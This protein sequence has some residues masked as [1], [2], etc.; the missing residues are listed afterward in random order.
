MIGETALFDRLP[1][2]YAL[3]LQSYSSI[4]CSLRLDLRDA[5]IYETIVQD[6]ALF[7]AV[8]RP[9]LVDRNIDV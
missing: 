4:F 8:E 5:V 1:F 9:R 7:S 3:V 6:I 2:A